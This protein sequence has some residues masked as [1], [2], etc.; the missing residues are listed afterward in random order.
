MESRRADILL[1]I[2]SARGFVVV[3]LSVL[4]I[5]KCCVSAMFSHAALAAASRRAAFGPQQAVDLGLGGPG[6][7]QP[8]VVEDELDEDCP[9][10]D[11]S[12]TSGTLV[13]DVLP[14]ASSLSSEQEGFRRD[15]LEVARS[16][17]GANA[18]SGTVHTYE[19]VL[20]GIIP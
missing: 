3:S 18:S 11:L 7:P 5:R 12:V 16:T 15:L 1:S 8:F 20:R 19:A 4:S 14:P 6:R 2:L 17:F 9:L 10:P 13:R